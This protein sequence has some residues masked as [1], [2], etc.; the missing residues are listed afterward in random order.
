MPASNRA[1]KASGVWPEH[2][3]GHATEHKIG[4]AFFGQV[5]L[6]ARDKLKYDGAILF[7]LNNN[8]P[9]TTVR[10]TLEYEMY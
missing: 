5:A 8:T 9:D 3:F 7:G 6:G 4:P 10:F 1:C 2:D